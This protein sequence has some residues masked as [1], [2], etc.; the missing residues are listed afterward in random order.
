[1]K[2]TCYSVPQKTRVWS[3]NTHNTQ[4]IVYNYCYTNSAGFN[5]CQSLQ[6]F[7]LMF[8]YP[9]I[10]KHITHIHTHTPLKEKAKA[11]CMSLQR[12]SQAGAGGLKKGL[13]IGR[14]RQGSDFTYHI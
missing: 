13:R 12:L 5:N 7:A 3:Q 10:D 14:M 11:Q 8:I 9:L 1:M 4:H 6:A 2:S